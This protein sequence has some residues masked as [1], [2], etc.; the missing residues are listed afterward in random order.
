MDWLHY[1]TDILLHIDKHLANIISD[2]GTLTY[3]ILFLVIFVE[4]G[5]VV[6]PFLPGDSLLFAAGA[7]VAMDAFN[8][9]ILLGVLGAAA[10]LGDTVNY[11]IGRSIGLRAY[12]LSWVNREHLDRAQAFY[13]TYGGKTIVLA[14]FVPIVRTFA[15]FVAGIGKMPYST[16]ILYNIVGGVAWVLICVFAGYFFGNIP[17]VKKN[18]ELVVLGI[19]LISILPIVLEV[20]KARKQAKQ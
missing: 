5:F 19:V 18:F 10:V 4:T 13:D 12:S 20:W 14:R 1:L 6:M 9:P 3:A 7:F 17:L 2:Y 8:L 16:F 15:P 11:W